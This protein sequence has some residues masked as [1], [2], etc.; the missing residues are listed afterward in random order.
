M[1]NATDDLTRFV[2]EALTR[3]SSRAQIEAVLKQA[4]WEAPQVGSAL[5]SFAEV[6]FAVPVPRPRPYLSARDAFLHLLLFATLYIAAINLGTVAFHLIDGWVPGPA[7]SAPA[8][9]YGAMAA[10]WAVSSLIVAVPVFL[11]L[12]AVTRRTVQADAGK[13]GSVLRRWL[14][15]L[16]LLVAAGVLIGDLISLVF[17][18]IG[19]EATLR[20]VLKVLTVGAIAGTTM[21]WLKMQAPPD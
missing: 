4:G 16:T 19:G 3:G 18:L 21:A 9:A 20:F 12:A 13:R 10:R 8:R 5:D 15:Y 7:V 14:T 17:N 2:R 11:W 6:P 1:A